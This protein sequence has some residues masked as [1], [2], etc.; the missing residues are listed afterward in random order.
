MTADLRAADAAMNDAILR[1]VAN[2]TTRSTV[3]AQEADKQR[4]SLHH[5]IRC[6]ITSGTSVADLV[7][8]TGLTRAR[9]Y[10]IRDHRR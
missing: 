4:E 8:V 2:A 5:L 7:Q 3:A 1:D 6:A 10:Q 9:I